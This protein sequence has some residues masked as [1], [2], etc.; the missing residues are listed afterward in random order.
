MSNDNVYES[1]FKVQASINKMVVDGKRKPTDVLR[2]LQRI[3]DNKDFVGIL[4]TP[5]S[6]INLIPSDGWVAEWQRFYQEVF[7]LEVNLDDAEIPSEQYGFWW[8]VIVMRGLTLKQ[9]WTKCAERF[10]VKTFYV[11][12]DWQGHLPVPTNDLDRSIPTH[13][14]TSAITYAK[15]FRGC[16][17]ADEE[18]RN[19]SADALAERNAQSITLLERLLLELWYH[20]KTGEHLNTGRNITLCA[21]SRDINGYLP[22]VYWEEDKLVVNEC[23]SSASA[24]NLR[25]RTAL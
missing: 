22:I 20:R 17:Q 14:R 25:A 10:S 13:D 5:E 7:N 1:L 23:S 2:F 19:L 11:F 8:V 16:V 18:N 9:V 3:V 6:A 12:N 15:R 4:D 24:C 21:G